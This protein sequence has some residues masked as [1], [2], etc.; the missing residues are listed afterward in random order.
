MKKIRKRKQEAEAIENYIWEQ[1]MLWIHSRIQKENVV[2]SIL[3]SCKYNFS[4]LEVAMNL[5]LEVKNITES[6]MPK[7]KIHISEDLKLSILKYSLRSN[8][9][10]ITMKKWMLFMVFHGFKL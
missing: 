3:P 6:D 10:V 4:S 7:R 9:C 5:H 1:L 2:V 8:F